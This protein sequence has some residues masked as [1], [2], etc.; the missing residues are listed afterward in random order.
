MIGE[1]PPLRPERGFE[2]T[3]T[4]RLRPRYEDIS[5]DGR[6]Q[7]TALSTAVGAVWKSLEA[8][9]TLEELRTQGV[10]PILQRLVMRGEPGPFSVNV[11]IECTGTWRVAR[12][13]DGD[14]I[15]LDMWLDAHAPHAMTL[16]PGPAPDAERVL[17]GRVYVEHVFT[18]PFA[19][20]SERKVSRLDL[21]GLPP[22]PEDTR[23]FASAE[24]LIAEHRLTN[25]REHRFGLLHTDSNQHV[26]SLVYPRL[27]EE[28]LALEE[29]E[30]LADAVELR[31]RKPFF[32]GDRATLSLA[33]IGSGIAVG[34]FTP[35]D[36]DRPNSTAAIRR[37]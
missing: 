1:I 20:A 22:L 21:R 26:N 27:F 5:Q 23:P 29:P 17:V 14:R 24:A 3:A 18:R 6:L 13:T 37:S 15:F 2:S 36:A 12:E 34:A 9:G 4:A 16:G 30:R 11:P 7:L 31:Y 19:P 10:L 28:A 33:H 35:P 8:T 25:V 32:A